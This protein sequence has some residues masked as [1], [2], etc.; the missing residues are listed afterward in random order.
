MDILLQAEKYIPLYPQLLRLKEDLFVAEISIESTPSGADISVMDYADANESD[1]SHWLLLGRAPFKTTMV[2]RGYYRVRAVKDGFATV[3][4]AIGI[5][6][7]GGTIQIRLHS[8]K[9]TPPGM[10]WVP[11]ITGGGRGTGQAFPTVIPQEAPE[12]WLDQHEVTNKEFEEFVHSGGYLKNEY[13]KNTFVKDGRPLSWE[14]AMKAFQDATGKP[15]PATWELGSYTESK[16][17]FPVGGVSWY[18][19]AAYCEFAGKSLPTVYHW[20]RAIGLGSAFD[21]D[22]LK[23]SNFSRKGPVAVRSSGALGAFGTYDMG[24]NMKEW[25]LNPTGELRYI[26]GGGWNEPPYQIGRP[27][28]RRPLDRESTFGIRCAKYPSP[29]PEAFLGPVPFAD[30]DR[31]KDKPVDDQTYRIYLSLHSYDKTALKPTVESVSEDSPYWRKEKISYRAAYGDET[32]NAN[33]YLPKGAT[34]PYQVVIYFGGTNTLTQKTYDDEAA[35]LDF[36]FIIRSG[37]AVLYPVYKGTFE[38]GPGAYYHQLG[39]P[40]RWRE[41]NLQWSKD[42]GRSIDYLETR[43]D[44]DVSKLA[45]LGGSMG[46][47]MSPRLIA[48]EPRIKAALLFLG[49]SFEKVPPEVDSWNF[50]P[51]VKIPVLMVNG[52]DDFLFPLESSQIPLFRALGTPEKDK[53]H[54]LYEGGHGWDTGTR[55][56][57]IKDALDWL[58]RYLGPVK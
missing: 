46:A 28:A 34:S 44:I 54:V 13:W 29:L 17:D 15:G 35:S 50:A 20:F 40:D 45:F 37:R 11:G 32:I 31:R 16:A 6:G 1:S 36:G 3:E 48:V 19:A 41:M 12:F 2:P 38:R 51:R 49:G 4:R 25:A 10:V 42:L 30:R 24:G 47:A 5:G 27:D 53:K 22:A 56:L 8:G 14:E 43:P 18:E 55:L 21:G 39:Q 9:D 26:L 52:K 33:L 57:V 23:L 58:D 7:A